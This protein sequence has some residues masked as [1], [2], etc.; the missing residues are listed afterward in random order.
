MRRPRK[1]QKVHVAY[2]VANGEEGEDAEPLKVPVWEPQNWQQQLANIRIMRSKKDAPVDQL[3]A[4]QCYDITAPPKV[5]PTSTC[6]GECMFF[7]RRRCS[8]PLR[9]LLEN[10]AALPAD[11][12]QGAPRKMCSTVT[13][14]CVQ[15]ASSV[16]HCGHWVCQRCLRLEVVHLG[17]SNNSREADFLILHR[18]LRLAVV[19]LTTF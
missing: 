14:Q 11:T 9:S 6:P 8:L 12:I 7:H 3:G 18:F 19:V 17:T 1:K 5:G 15:H 16:N 4:E 10:R 2:E 13:L